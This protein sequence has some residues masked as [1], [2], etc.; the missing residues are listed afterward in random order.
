M[1]FRDSVKLF[2]AEVFSHSLQ[3]RDKEHEIKACVT[4]I[5][6][7]H[8]MFLSLCRA[9]WEHIV[10]LLFTKPCETDIIYSC[11]IA[12]K[13]VTEK[14]SVLR[15]KSQAGAVKDLSSELSHI[16]NHSAILG[17][18]ATRGDSLETEL[19]LF[20]FQMGELQKSEVIAPL[21]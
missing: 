13:N 9:C 15:L 1:S 16:L 10:Q 14:S 18:G 6:Q 7:G 17:Q 19:H 21:V 5:T 8:F 11:F 20:V 4:L 2:L 12:E 3:N